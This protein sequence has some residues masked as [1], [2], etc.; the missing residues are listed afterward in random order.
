MPPEQR[1]ARRLDA[2]TQIARLPILAEIESAFSPPTR[3]G[4]RAR[5][6]ARRRLDLD[7]VGAALRQHPGACRPRDA[8]AEIENANAFVG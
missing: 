4:D 5:P 3:L 2:S 8:L 7:D 1:A 6:I